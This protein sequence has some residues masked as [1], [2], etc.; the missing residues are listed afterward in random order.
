[1]PALSLFLLLTATHV[2]ADAAPDPSKGS[3]LLHGC[4]AEVRLMNLPRLD[5]A[6]SV[7]LIDGAYCSG[8]L[9]G[10]LAGLSPA[11]VCSDQESMG[12][13]FNTYVHYMEIHPEL[14]DQDKRIGLRLALGNAYP[15]P[16]TEQ[17][18]LPLG[19]DHRTGF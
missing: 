18:T 15:C 9:T 3:S 12:A 1:M 19:S 13:L 6:H 2:I 7:D 14:E 8:Y 17:R 16:A 11:S 5:Q 4:R 10:F